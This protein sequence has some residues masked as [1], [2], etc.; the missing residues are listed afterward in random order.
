MNPPFSGFYAR[1]EG[2]CIP[3]LARRRISD[4]RKTYAFISLIELNWCRLR[5]GLSDDTSGPDS[6]SST[7]FEYSRSN[8]GPLA[9][10]Q[11]A[12][13]YYE[14]VKDQNPKD[15]ST[16]VGWLFLCEQPIS[17]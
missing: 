11:I 10:R 16:H 15:I 5:A 8:L 14:V 6:Q 2:V 17:F 12:I 3:F 9:R 13:V 4:P 7:V 1:R